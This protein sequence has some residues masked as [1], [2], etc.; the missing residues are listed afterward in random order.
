MTTRFGVRSF[1]NDVVVNDPIATAYT[2]Y[3]LYVPRAQ[4]VVP[5][6]ASLTTNAILTPTVSG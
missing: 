4:I 1:S 6:G 3:G 5:V 2:S